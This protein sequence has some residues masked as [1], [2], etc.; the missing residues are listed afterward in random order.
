MLGSA[1]RPQGAEPSGSPLSDMSA[2]DD[3]LLLSDGIWQVRLDVAGPVGL[4]PRH[5]RQRVSYPMVEGL[6]TQVA[7]KAGLA[8]PGPVGE[9]VGTQ[10]RSGW[11]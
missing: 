2:S 9:G 1:R 3:Y 11:V 5:R 6:V 7:A 10:A 8:A 4:A